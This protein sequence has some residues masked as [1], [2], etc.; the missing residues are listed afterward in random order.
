MPYHIAR[1]EED[2]VVRKWALMWRSIILSALDKTYLPYYSY[3]RYLDL[4]D[5]GYLLGEARFTGGLREFVVLLSH[6]INWLRYL[7][8]LGSEFFSPELHDFLSRDYES[9][10]NKRLRSSRVFPDSSWVSL[11]CGSGASCVISDFES[12]LMA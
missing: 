7:S 11:K 6:C 8:D 12:K 3:I 1:N 10:G 9:K 2:S 5:L 4:D